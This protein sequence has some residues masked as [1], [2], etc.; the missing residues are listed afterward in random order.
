MMETEII[1]DVDNVISVGL[2]PSNELLPRGCDEVYPSVERSGSVKMKIMKPMLKCI[3]C[4]RC[5]RVEKHAVM[6]EGFLAGLCAA[7]ID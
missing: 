7:K 4:R 2:T 1:Y 5:Y 3:C 6:V